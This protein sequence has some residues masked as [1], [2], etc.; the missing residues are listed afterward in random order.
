MLHFARQPNNCSA[1]PCHV[2]VWPPAQTSRSAQ[3]RGE[4]AAGTSGCR[5]VIGME[6][7]E[8]GQADGETEARG[9]ERPVS[10]SRALARLGYGACSQC[11]IQP[12]LLGPAK[13]LRDLPRRW[14]GRT[15]SEQLLCF[16]SCPARQ[17]AMSPQFHQEK[18]CFK[19]AG[20][21][22]FPSLR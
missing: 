19:A 18:S 6:L 22:I 4:G 3:H 8:R 12:A 9:M 13:A 21:E 17:G 2:R 16:S 15:C 1:L 5:N 7:L 11:S 10:C 14:A 20:V